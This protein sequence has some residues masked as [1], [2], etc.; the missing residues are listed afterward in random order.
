MT[1]EKSTK[2]GTLSLGGTL[3]VA[4]GSS[5][6]SSSGVAV[7]VR[8]RRFS[9]DKKST[10]QSADAEMAR[11]MKVLEEARKNEEAEKQKREAEL[12]KVADLQNKQAEA[13]EEARR[14]N[15]EAKRVAEEAAR[16][17]AEEEA[18]KAAESAQPVQEDTNARGKGGGRDSKSKRQ[19]L[20]V[21]EGRKKQGAAQGKKRG[22]NA[23]MEELEQRY[24]TMPGRKK[25]GARMEGGD[26]AS[27]E[28]VIR[29]VEIP[30]FITVQELAARMT[31]K[32]SDVVKTLMMMGEMV[33]LTQTLDQETAILVVEEFGHNYTTVSESDI[34]EGL[35]DE[36]DDPKDLKE[37]PPVVTVMGHV[38]HGKT[39]LL[40]SL[41]NASVVAG[42]A[43]GITQHIGAYQVEVPSSSRKITFLDTPGHAAFTAMRARG[44]EVT[45]VVILVVAADDGVMPQTA[46]AIQHAKAAGVPIVV[47]INKM[48]KPEANPDRV[49]NDLLNHDLILEDFGGEVP[50]VPISALTGQGLEEL[51]E[52]VLLQ[53]DVLELKASSKR[54]ADGIVV[55]AELD[56]G[57]GSVATVVVQRGTLKVGDIMVAGSVW[58]R[59]RALINDR[60]ENVEEAGPSTPVEVLGLQGV[61]SAG[62]T[63]AVVENNERAKEVAEYREQKHR[64]M[65]QA[66]RKMS[67]DNLF[68]RMAEVDRMELNAIVKADVQ[69][70]VEA[71][72]H[73]LEQLNMPQVKVSVINGGVGVITETDIN[74]AISSGAFVAAFNVRADATARKLAEQE[75][76]EIRYYSVI[77]NLIDDIKNAMAGLLEP[78]YVEEQTGAAEVRAIFKSGKI[79]IAGCMVTD[80]TITRGTQARL[81]RDGVVVHEGTISTIRR[82]KDDV[83]EIKSGFECGMTFDKYDDLQE[84]DVIESYKMNA[85]TKT[86]EDLEKLA[87]QKEAQAEKEAK[88]E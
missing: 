83:K 46:E 88:A 55:E 59:V 27:A 68:D 87:A 57:R 79:K 53:A 32:G 44:A 45:D 47:A 25:Q 6:S 38:D 31:E 40:D 26:K 14:K 36:Q 62:D 61:P 60:G 7:E 48:D 42:E 76:V 33:T 28:K 17:Q 63:F 41:R 77:Y 3:G 5:G 11:R 71:I 67:L 22:R 69:G 85:V 50:S 75:G 16:R 66:A 13:A 49:K 35:V 84:G 86:F 52:V 72:K 21:D 64:E 74:L 70:S 51:E 56:K 1:N 9:E 82:E 29:D 54:R 18:R 8:R 78:D 34:E 30:D 10:A 37:R 12:Q 81:V 19:T 43:G 2:K 4:G 20:T 23:Y 39:T 58:G 65:V 15:E 80:G 73:S 24:R